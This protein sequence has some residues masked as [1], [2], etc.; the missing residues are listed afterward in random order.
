MNNR[1]RQEKRHDDPR[2]MLLECQKLIGN[3]VKMVEELQNTYK[4]SK[5]QVLNIVWPY[6]QK[7]I[8]G[9]KKGYILERSEGNIECLAETESS[10][11]KKW[12]EIDES[13]RKIISESFDKTVKGEVAAWNSEAYKN[14]KGG[15][16]FPV[17]HKETPG[18]G[19]SILSFLCENPDGEELFFI[20]V[21]YGE[22]TPFLSH[23]TQAF[24]LTSRIV[25]WYLNYV[26]TY[27]LLI[28]GK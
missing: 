5:Q 6:I 16:S 7:V 25:G 12:Q 1:E 20:I 15:I 2:N 4:A 3:L 9:V 17:F 22:K 24:K 28:F 14:E 23:E 21:R 18:E 10:D 13:S 11:F 27:H 19:N 8:I 26:L